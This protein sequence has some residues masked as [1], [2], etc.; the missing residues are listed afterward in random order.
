M[1]RTFT[2]QQA[3]RERVPLLVGL[4]G[5]SGSGKTYS[6]LRLATGMQR[7]TGG[8][9]FYID[10]EARRALHYADDF[11]FNHVP[12]DP[13]FSPLDYLEA[14][15]YCVAQ[16]AS[17][18]IVDSLS[19]EHEGPGGVLE[20]H[21]QF[22]DEK[23]GTDWD[24]RQKLNFA[25]WIKPKG[26]RQRLINT[27][28]QLGVNLI[29][30][31]RAKEKMK[32]QTGAQPKELGWM[33]IAGAEFLYEMTATCL[34][35]PRSDGTPT[36]NPTLPGERQMAKLPKQFIDAFKE[37]Q[38]SEDIGEKLAQWAAGDEKPPSE[39]EMVAAVHEATAAKSVDELQTIGATHG[40][41]AW[42]PAHR[43]EI[44]RAINARK[45]TIEKESQ[46]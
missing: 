31:F 22:L 33:P 3:K 24:K 28:L 42:T 35:Y 8:T 23:A 41:R 44:K 25:A 15:E 36:W 6:A 19:H 9:I 21:D 12:F 1:S 39:D 4:I 17:I 45:K 30:C 27:M 43:L 16:K 5:A 10:T 26:Q 34:L 11:D 13:P 37:E 46:P 20:M 14:I 7:V 38:L 2:S 40:S 32:L 18:V 29:C